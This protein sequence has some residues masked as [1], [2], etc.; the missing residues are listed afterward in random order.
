MKGLIWFDDIIKKLNRKHNVRQREV[1]EV[2]SSKLRFR[3]V[4]PVFLHNL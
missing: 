3:F 2:L 1:R 4:F